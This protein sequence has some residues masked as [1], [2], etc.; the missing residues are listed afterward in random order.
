MSASFHP[1]LNK[2]TFIKQNPLKKTH[3]RELEFLFLPIN[4]R[5]DLSITKNWSQKHNWSTEMLDWKSSF[6]NRGACCTTSQLIIISTAL[7]Q[8]RSNLRSAGM[9]KTFQRLLGFISFFLLKHILEHHSKQADFNL[10]HFTLIYI[11]SHCV[12]SVQIRSIFLSVFFCIRT[13]YGDL[14]RKSPYSVRIQENT[15][16]KILRIWTHFT[17][18]QQCSLFFF[19]KWVSFVSNLHAAKATYQQGICFLGPLISFLLQ[20]CLYL[21]FN[22]YICE[23]VHFNKAAVLWWS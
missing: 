10:W 7:D 20:K 6:S 15:D 16:K 4:T 9:T 5:Q 8:A 21:F 22:Y 13:E 3:L 12:K 19:I 17:Q 14:P 2:S 11:A 1:T 18:C 23:G